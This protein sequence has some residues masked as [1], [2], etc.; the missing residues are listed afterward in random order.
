M[1]QLEDFENQ[2]DAMKR[3]LDT[4][5]MQIKNLKKER[6][7]LEIR[8]RELKNFEK[9][10]DE[11]LELFQKTKEKMLKEDLIVQKYKNSCGSMY[12]K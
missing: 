5:S 2:K 3:S 10:I 9:S 12:L 8:T 1:H 6:E 4:I 11:K 7:E